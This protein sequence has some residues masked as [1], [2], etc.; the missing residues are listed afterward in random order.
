MMTAHLTVLS[1][2]AT[3]HVSFMGTDLV[4]ARGALVPRQE[5]ELLGWAA[6]GILNELPPGTA[7]RLVD[8]CCGAGNL[9]CGI[10]SKSPGLRAWASDLTDGAVAVA[11]AN[12]ERLDL[13]S[14]IQVC[15]GDLFE[16]LAGLDL[17]ASVDVVVCNPPYISTGKLARDRAELL[18]HE[19]RAAFDGGPFGISILARVVRD[20]LTFLKPGGM[21]LFEVGVGQDEMVSRLFSRTGS[22]APVITF[23]DDQGRPRVVGA[24]KQA[25]R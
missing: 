17:E 8:M 18:V 23:T 6:L 19:P 11:R 9:V 1:A 5:T 10:T 13:S 2:Y 25:V 3:G 16:P 7:P 21:L 14:R 20:A 12:V 24:R 4:A 15:Q 22:Y